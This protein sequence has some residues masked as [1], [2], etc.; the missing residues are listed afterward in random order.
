MGVIVPFRS[1]QPSQIELGR[2]Q[3]EQGIN[4]RDAFT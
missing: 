2:D 1:A 4:L 3:I